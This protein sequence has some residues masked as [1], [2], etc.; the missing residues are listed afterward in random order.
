M[1]NLSRHRY[2]F[3]TISLIHVFVTMKERLEFTYAVVIPYNEWEL[4]VM[5]Y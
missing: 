5:F 1:L 4:I 2:I 3:M